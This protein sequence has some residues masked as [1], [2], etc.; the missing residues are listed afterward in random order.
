MGNLALLN[1]EYTKTDIYALT[2][3]AYEQIAPLYS[4]K[5]SSINSVF[6]IARKFIVRLKQH[7]KIL[8]VGCG[9][10]RDLKFFS[11]LG[12]RAM[13]ID[14]SR[15][16]VKIAR[17]SCNCKVLEMDVLSINLREEKFDAI[18]ANAILHH[19]TDEDIPN[20]LNEFHSLLRTKGKLFISMKRLQKFNYLFKNSIS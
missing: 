17:S 6:P 15:N 20:V 13:G 5:C 19:I 11:S 1:K 12:Y 7:S 2:K 14:N 10:G 9:S 4:E 18:W 8:D 3:M 16:L